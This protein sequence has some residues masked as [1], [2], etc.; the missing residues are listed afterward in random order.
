MVR[1]IESSSNDQRDAVVRV[2]VRTRL[3]LSV[4]EIHPEQMRPQESPSPSSR[5][6][7]DLNPI[8]L[9][10]HDVLVHS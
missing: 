2:Q 6:S 4:L 5:C 3:H 10:H 7:L 9:L 1:R 8:L